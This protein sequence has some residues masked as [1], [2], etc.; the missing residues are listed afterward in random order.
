VPRRPI[1][2]GLKRTPARGSHAEDAEVV[3]GHRLAGK[4]QRIG[5][6]P[7]RHQDVVFGGECLEGRGET[8]PVEEIRRSRG[9]HHAGA[10][11]FPDTHDPIAVG[12]RQ[13]L[14]ASAISR[15]AAIS[16]SS[17]RSRWSPRKSARS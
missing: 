4:A 8:P 7:H 2:T 10:G 13:R 6:A 3:G 9:I 12:E 5:T 11:R 1:V 15:C 14:S 17:S 16:S